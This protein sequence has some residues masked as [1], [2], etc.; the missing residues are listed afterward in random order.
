MGKGQLAEDWEKNIPEK[1][2]GNSEA[3]VSAGAEGCNGGGGGTT[4]VQAGGSGCVPGCRNGWYGR[5]GRDRTRKPRGRPAAAGEASSGA[6]GRVR[7]T[8]HQ[9]EEGLGWR[10]PATLPSAAGTG[11][12]S[13]QVGDGGRWLGQGGS[14][15]LWLGLAK[16]DRDGTWQGVQQTF[17]QTVSSGPDCPLWS[18]QAK[19]VSRHL[20]VRTRAPR[21]AGCHRDQDG[22]R[23]KGGPG[24]CTS[25]P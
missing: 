22:P 18:L 16:W 11:L 25:T 20:V 24:P 13:A 23:V 8:G 4:N 15:Q 14:P 3:C 21:R 7:R 6:G 10:G 12:Q 5:Q 2:E 1:E 19:A 17:S 9:A